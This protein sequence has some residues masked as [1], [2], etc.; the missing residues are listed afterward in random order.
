MSA[1]EKIDSQTGPTT[2]S[3]VYLRL[4]EDRWQQGDPMSEAGPEVEG[5]QREDDG[6]PPQRADDPAVPMRLQ[7]H[8]GR[9]LVTRPAGPSKT[10]G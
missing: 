10:R 6:K 2:P 8:A 1:N 9:E 5:A 3:T 7:S 4:S